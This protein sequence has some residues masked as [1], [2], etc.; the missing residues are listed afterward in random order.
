MNLNF[1][2]LIPSDFSSSSRVWIYQSNRLFTLNEALALEEKLIEFTSSW[3]SH[4]NPV[5]GF[6]SLFFGQF[7]VLMADEE[8]AGVSGCSIDS[9]V[10]LM[11]SIE[12]EFNVSL[13]DRTTLAFYI[14]E[15]VQLLPLSQIQYS[16]EQSF[17]SKE[18]LFFDNTVLS[19]ADLLSKWITPVHQSWIGDRFSSEFIG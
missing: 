10:R 5:K 17:I 11:K 18:T 13:F 15:T 16:I 9:S 8:V 7:I 12:E 4:G 1:S 3:K 6:G 19:K 2:H 14:N